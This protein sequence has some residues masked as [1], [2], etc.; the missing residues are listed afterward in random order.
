MK[1]GLRNFILLG[2][3]LTLA[4]LSLPSL[5]PIDAER[6]TVSE[7]FGR[8]GQGRSHACVVDGDTIRIGQRRIRILGIDAPELR[9]PK[10]ASERALAERA[11]Q[12]L[13]RLLNEGP[14]ELVRDVRE[15]KDDYDRDLRRIVRV[16]PDGSELSIGDE[17]IRQGLA[18]PY[19]GRKARWC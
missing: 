2:V 3:L 17:L 7:R 14:F 8:C 12:E 5:V 11:T 9:D 16:Q 19:L 6:E 13:Q 4:V 18:T 15:D 10:C 1:R